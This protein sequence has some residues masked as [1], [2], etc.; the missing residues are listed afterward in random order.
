MAEASA[1]PVKT[2]SI[3]FTHEKFNELPLAR[4]VAQRFGTEHTSSSS[5]LARSSSSRGSCATTA[6]RSPTPRR[7][8]RFYLAE[9]ARRH[10]TVALNG[11]G[12]DESFGGYTRYVANAASARLQRIPLALRRGARGRRPARP[13]ERHDRLV[14][15]PRA[16]HGGDARARRSRSATWRYMTH[17]NGLRRERLYTRRLPRA[18]RALGAADVMERPVARVGRRLGGRR[19]ARRRRADLPARRSAGQ[20]GHRDHG[21]RR[22]RRARRSSTTS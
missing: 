19:D 10:V 6:S 3:G 13:R 20:D 12:G 11:D 1:R 7:S 9:M 21:A 5:S 14:A 2:F 22:W 16:P 17:L 8:R 18:G 4:L 15:Q